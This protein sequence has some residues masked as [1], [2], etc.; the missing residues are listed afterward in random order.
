MGVLRNI[1]LKST[2]ALEDLRIFLDFLMALSR[3]GCHGMSRTVAECCG[4]SRNDCRDKAHGKLHGNHDPNPNPN[5]WAFCCDMPRHAAVHI[6]ACQGSTLCWSF[7]WHCPR[8]ATACAAA[9]VAACAGACHGMSRA[10]P[11]KSQKYS[12]SL[13]HD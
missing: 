7:S 1:N 2:R 13:A 9:H 5:P 6:G 10:V 8:H 11:Q 12:T 3:H 4:M